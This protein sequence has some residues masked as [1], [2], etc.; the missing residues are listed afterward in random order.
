M[1]IITIK[2]IAKALN[3]S[4]STISRALRGSHE[5]SE[6]TKK[7]VLEYA[8]T[9]N[10]SPNPIA[11]SL[12]ENKSR[13]IG[14]L[15]P[16]IDNPFFSQEINGIETVCYAKGYHVMIFQS[17]ESLNREIINVQHMASR[18]VDGIIISLS[19]ETSEIQH[20][21]FL[22]S[23]GTPIVFFDRTSDEIVT[24]KVVADNFAGAYNA[25]E[26]LIKNGKKRIGHIGASAKLSISKERL[27][28]YVA[29]LSKNNI[30]LDQSLVRA[31]E[32]SF[33]SV[34]NE[35]KSLLSL[36]N[37]IDALFSVSDRMT[38][39]CMSILQKLKIKVPEQLSFICFTNS[40]A[41]NL[42]MPSLSTVFQP[43]YEMGK[44]AAELLLDQIETKPKNK[45]NIKFETLILKTELIVRD[46]S[47]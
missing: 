32:Y 46:S 35:I 47:G 2:D 8:N 28:G 16:E 36:D 25:T 18:R 45:D 41:A 30:P 9:H 29:A 43:A 40:N 26:L 37:P 14:V 33:E 21:K 27:A 3:L 23:N 17:Y 13:S 5:I 20:L 31:C 19:A 22:H 6:A 10:Y 15:V 34:E 7:T 38:I 24:H 39:L 1:E 4:A 12:K 11:L 42:F 44:K